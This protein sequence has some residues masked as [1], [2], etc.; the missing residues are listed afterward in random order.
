MGNDGYTACIKGGIKGGNTRPYPAEESRHNLSEARLWTYQITPSDKPDPEGIKDCG[1]QR[2][3]I[4]HNRT[5]AQFFNNM[6]AN[7]AT[8][9]ALPAVLLRDDAWGLGY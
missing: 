9:E 6:E 3:R 4:A 7:E 8:V 1:S 5:F 2:C